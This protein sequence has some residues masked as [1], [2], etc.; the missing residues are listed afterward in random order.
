MLSWLL[1][2]LWHAND[3]PLWLLDSYYWNPENT[4]AEFEAGDIQSIV[5][6]LGMLANSHT[7][8]V[9][10]HMRLPSIDRSGMDRREDP[11]V[12]CTTT[13][14]GSVF[15]RHVGIFNKQQQQRFG[16]VP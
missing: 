15:T 12:G 8:L 7:G 5:P 16:C 2:L 6:G 3:E 10:A 9:N 13:K 14:C 1:R 11:G 4:A